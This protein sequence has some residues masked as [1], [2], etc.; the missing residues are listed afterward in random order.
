MNL[1]EMD[2]LRAEA[3]PKEINTAARRRFLNCIVAKPT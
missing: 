2:S 1:Y 3:C